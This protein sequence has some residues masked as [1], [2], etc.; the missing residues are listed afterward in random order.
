MANAGWCGCSGG[1]LI[2]ARPAL[3]PYLESANNSAYPKNPSFPDA[4]AASSS[5]AAPTPL[6]ILEILARHVQRS[7]PIGD[8]QSLSGMDANR[9]S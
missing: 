5:A 8:L 7:L 6:A 1:G 3:T 2:P 9:V 4:P